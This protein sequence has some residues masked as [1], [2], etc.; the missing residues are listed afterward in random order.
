M[1]NAPVEE[2]IE[3]VH[4]LLDEDKIFTGHQTDFFFCSLLIRLSLSAQDFDAI[5]IIQEFLNNRPE[6]EE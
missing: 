4:S 6:V 3:F 2:R 5:D 1:F